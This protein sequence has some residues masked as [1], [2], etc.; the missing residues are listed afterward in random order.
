MDPAAPSDVVFAL[1]VHG[2]VLWL[3]VAMT[4]TMLW[5]VARAGPPAH[6]QVAR[7]A[8]FLGV[9]AIPMP[10]PGAAVAFPVAAFILAPGFLVVWLAVRRAP[11]RWPVL[12]FA[13]LAT[14]TAALDAATAWTAGADPLRN[15]SALLTFT[16][17]PGAESAA[18]I[19]LGFP[20]DIAVIGLA[21][22]MA[23]VVLGMARLGPAFGE[24][25]P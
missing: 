2:G 14:A 7:T 21:S 24:A 15:L 12:L 19:F 23:L 10:M 5:M 20:I 17:E 9:L 22:R 3:A 6:R 16:A 25:R 11:R 4:A 1:R 18:R 13:V 8:F